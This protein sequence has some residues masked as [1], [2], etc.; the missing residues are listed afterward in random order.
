MLEHV[1]AADKYCHDVVAGKIPACSWVK[2]ACQRQIDDLARDWEYEFDAPAGDRAC[3]FIELLP[4]VKGSW[5][6]KTIVL[7]PWQKFI[8]STVYGWKRKADGYRRFA[9][10]YVEVPRKNAK[11][12][13]LAAVSLYAMALDGEEGSEVYSAATNRDQAKVVFNIA[14]QMANKSPEFRDR[15]G[16][17]V[18]EHKI[19]QLSSQSI[20][21]PLA[22][23]SKGLDGLNVH[24]AGI[25]ELHAHKTRAVFDVLET[26]TGSREQPLIWSITTAGSN[27]AGIC[28]EQR[29]YLTKVLQNV[30]PD[31]TYFGAIYTLD[32]GDDP[33]DPMVWAKA[34]PNYGVSVKEKDMERLAHKAQETPSAKNNFLTKRLDVWVNAMSAWLD[35]V[36]WAACADSI[37]L[38][39]FEGEDCIIAVDLA[40]KIDIAAAKL[41]FNR[42]GTIYEFGR[43]YLPEE[44]VRSARNSQYSGWVDEGR[45]ITTPG[46]RISYDKIRDDILEDHERFHVLEVVV[47]PWQATHLETQLMEENVEVVELRNT[48]QNFSEP[49]KEIE[50]DVIAGTYKHDGCPVMSWMISNVVCFMDAKEN[51]YPR[52]ESEPN[53]IDGVV[54]S[55]MAKNRWIYRE[56]EDGGIEIPAGY[57]MVAL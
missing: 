42:E 49:M 21:E 17:E 22:G 10:V 48:V 37:R 29:S 52:K 54:A 12:T 41:T 57:E 30:T 28:Y 53:K 56:P 7:E 14:R 4:H 5:D 38:E 32:D 26:A 16:V 36:A 55:I 13:L 2:M 46:F 15:F 1:T 6:S 43:Y 40:S 51:V 23:D 50:A 20:M 3:C 35:P 24:L 27:Q 44:T 31:E 33:F 8:V 9:T 39:D 18:R 34:N 25:D 19:L 11:S 47:D 45:I